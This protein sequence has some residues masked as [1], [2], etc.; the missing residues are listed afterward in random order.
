M[1]AGPSATDAVRSRDRFK[2]Q[3]QKMAKQVVALERERTYLRAALAH[4][5]ATGNGRDSWVE[6]FVPSEGRVPSTGLGS[7]TRLNDPMLYNQR[8]RSF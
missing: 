7:I 8:T 4:G 1:S 5:G 6:V 2:V 3:I